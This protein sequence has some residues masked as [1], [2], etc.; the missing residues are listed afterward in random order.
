V[1]DHPLADRGHAAITKSGHADTG[2]PAGPRGAS[3]LPEGRTA[4][5]ANGGTHHWMLPGPVDQNICSSQR[6]RGATTV[7]S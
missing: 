5:S 3:D 2:H 6:C 1:W 7:G 4:T